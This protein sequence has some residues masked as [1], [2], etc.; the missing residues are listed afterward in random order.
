MKRL[1]PK[2]VWRVMPF[3]PVACSLFQ[4]LQVDPSLYLLAFSFFA[5]K[6]MDYSLRGVV[7]EMVRRVCEV[8]VLLMKDMRLSTVFLQHRFTCRWILKVAMW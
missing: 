5:A 1:E 2:L 4:S 6:C 3:I 8:Q 7:N